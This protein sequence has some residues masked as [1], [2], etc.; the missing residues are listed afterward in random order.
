M[1]SEHLLNVIE[2]SF[3]IIS[4]TLTKLLQ[5]VLLITYFVSYNITKLLTT[6]NLS[7]NLI[8]YKMQYIIGRNLILL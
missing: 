1:S 5:M 4:G 6:A 2:L 8:R 3:G 7:K